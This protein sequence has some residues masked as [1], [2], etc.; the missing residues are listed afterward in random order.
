MLLFTGI[1]FIAVAFI[2]YTSAAKSNNNKVADVEGK[3]F[4]LVEL[5][6]SE[7]CSSCPA[8]DELV[9]KVEKEVGD[10]PV[11][12]LAYHVDY[13]DRLGWKDTFSNAAYTRRQ[14]QYAGWLNLSQIYTPQIV[15]NGKTEFV[16][17]QESALRKALNTGLQAG[18]EV[19]LS[20]MASRN[21]GNTATIRY[22]L[23]GGAASSSEVL[24]LAT[25]QKQAVIK[26][27]SGENGG[28]TLAHTQ[29]VRNLQSLPLSKSDGTTTVSLPAGFDP[30]NWELIGFVQNTANG[31]VSG[32]SKTNFK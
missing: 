17:S 20:L 23:E 2:N 6:T 30:G 31:A 24:L 22:K 25:V 19:Q 4:A 5:F 15:V 7:G 10:K 3:G 32:A 27:K 29:I 13:W 21:A 8:A 9:A 11:Y 12:I 28:R 14:K 26:V 1:A 16:G 18:S